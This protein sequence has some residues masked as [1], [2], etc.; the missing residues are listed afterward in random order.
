MPPNLLLQIGPFSVY[1]FGVVLAAIFFLGVFLFW[2]AATREGFA[3]DPIFDLIFLSA[4][5]TLVGGR[6]SFI[7]LTGEPPLT[8]DPLAI[9]RV[10]EGIFWAPA[11]FFGLSAFYLYTKQRKEWSFLKLADLAVP[12]LALGQGIGYLGAEVTSY[13]T[14]AVWAGVGFL[15][16]FLILEFTRRRITASGIIFF[17]YLLLGGLLTILSEY[18]RIIKAFAFGVDLNYLLGAVLS[19]GGILGLLYLFVR[20]KGILT[21]LRDK[22]TISPFIFIGR[23]EKQ[24]RFRLKVGQRSIRLWREK[25]DASSTN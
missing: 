3:S 14:S 15:G 18:L 22:I 8:D 23:V 13:I 21:V 16:L 6:L 9:L 2:R 24:L 10:G 17:V 19:I 5:A 4:L 25:K 12:L 20:S 7:I 1:T 11:F